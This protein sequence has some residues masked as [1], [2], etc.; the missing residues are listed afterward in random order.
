MLHSNLS[1]GHLQKQVFFLRFFFL[2]QP[3]HGTMF[4]PRIPKETP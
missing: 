4:I 2:Y 1:Y 3:H